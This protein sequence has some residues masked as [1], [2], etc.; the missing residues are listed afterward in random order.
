MDKDLQKEINRTKREAKKVMR[1]LYG[2][3]NEWATKVTRNRSKPN[4]KKRGKVKDSNGR[5]TKSSKGEIQVANWLKSRGMKF[6]KEYC[7]EVT[8]E[9]RIRKL[10]FDFYLP[11]YKTL[12]EFDG[13]HHF[14][15][16]FGQANFEATVR[17]DATKN[18]WAD[19]KGLTLIRIHHKYF[20]K[21]GFVLSKHFFS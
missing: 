21:V 9:G 1:K 3:T 4:K 19:R 20:G 16:V 6:I 7:A 2:C 13:Q 8:I 17:N 18:R 15:P 5:N 12:I 10:W 14:E 11:D